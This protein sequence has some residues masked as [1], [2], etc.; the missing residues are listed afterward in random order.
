MRQIFEY[1]PT[2]AYRFIPG[3]QVRIPHESGGYLIRTNS[4]GFRC[5]HEFT[6]PKTPGKRR[7]LLFGDSFTAGDGVSNGKRFGDYLESMI[8]DLE[9][10]NFGMPGT[11]TDQHYLIWRDFA[12]GI[13]ADAVII[14]ALVENIRRVNSHSRRFQN[15][16]GEEC[17]Y[18][19][20]YFELE[21]GKPV[22]H[23]VPVQREPLTPEQLAANDVKTA[24]TGRFLLLRNAVNKLGLRDIAQKV[25][26]YQPLPEYD[27][28]KGHDWLL[29]RAILLDWIPQVPQ[30]VALMPFPLSQYIEDTA[31]CDNV[32][33][34]FREVAQEAG[35]AMHDVLPDLKKH[36]MEERRT[37]RFPVDVHPTP[38]GHEEVAKSL[39]PTVEKLLSR[40]ASS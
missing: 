35:C 29:M 12:Q 7:V 15:D 34:R 33:A 23:N 27:D 38:K 21:D 11:G 2:I 19:K 39:V 5:A 40:P 8:P 36:P 26:G 16:K 6:A 14:S 30:P 17:I 25:T 1:H 10:F 28:P 37:F 9:V 22:L 24:R 20:P 4:A 3:L 32:I 18:A 13:E 31:P